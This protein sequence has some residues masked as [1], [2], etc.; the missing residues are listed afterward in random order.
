MNLSTFGN[1]YLMMVVVAIQGGV[2]N[3]GTGNNS[4][5]AENIIVYVVKSINDLKLALI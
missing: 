5:K 4:I 3:N 1:L 2:H